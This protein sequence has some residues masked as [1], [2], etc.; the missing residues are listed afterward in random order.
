MKTTRHSLNPRAGFTLME[1]LTVM[2]IIAII[3]TI[4]L[5]SYMNMKA[6]GAYQ[7][8]SKNLQ[9]YVMLARQQAS[10]QNK[11]VCLMITKT[12]R[13]FGNNEKETHHEA[14]VVLYAGTVTTAAGD[15]VMDAFFSERVALSM[16]N[17]VYNL[18]TGKRATIREAYVT[19][20]NT[21]VVATLYTSTPLPSYN[22]DVIKYKLDTASHGFQRGH[23]YGFELHQPYRLP[24]NFTLKGSHPI[25]EKFG[26]D[27]S[28]RYCDD[29]SGVF[30][31]VG[32]GISFDLVESIRRH[33]INITI[34]SRGVVTVN[35]NP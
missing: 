1:L 22:Y 11:P 7:S 27:G 35:P 4:A 6:G 18:S 31:H 15:T 9:N 32:T 12:D 10:L 19:H 29:G 14:V 33:P 28:M 26:G 5:I 16:T 3:S 13:T 2:A 25:V 24:K 20:E 23:A 8:L 17:Y 30:K 34:D 21:N